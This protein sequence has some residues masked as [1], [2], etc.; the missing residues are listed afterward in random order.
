MEG[1]KLFENSFSY[2][3]PLELCFIVEGK[4]DKQKLKPLVPKH[5]IILCTNGTISE[6]DLLA[7]VEPYDMY[8][9]ITLFDAD[10]NGEKLRKLMRKV[11]PEAIQIEI[12]ITY[13]EVAETPT[14]IL[15]ELL[16]KQ[17]IKVN[18]K[19]E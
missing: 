19:N 2:N 12:P 3:D 14:H 18:D 16:K 7:L 9:L 1:Y 17:K 13:K 10:K 4:S 8:E 15:R 6:D 11:Y 5:A